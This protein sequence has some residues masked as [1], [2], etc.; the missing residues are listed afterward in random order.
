MHEVAVQ[1]HS[2]YVSV[3]FGNVL[4]SRGSVVPTFLQQI[5]EGGPVT[6]TSG[7]KR[8]RKSWSGTKSSCAGI[9]SL[10]FRLRITSAMEPA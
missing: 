5:A 2:G 3:R 8:S 1:R 7:G 6:I 9:T 10:I 4:G